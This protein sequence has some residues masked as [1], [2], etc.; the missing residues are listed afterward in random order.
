MMDTVA[1]VCERMA[2]IGEQSPLAP[3][4]EAQARARFYNSANAF[5]IKL[6]AVPSGLLPAPAADALPGFYPCDQ[7][8]D[9][10]SPSVAT[11]PNLLARY[12]QL[13]AGEPLVSHFQA[14]G[15]IWYV[16]SGEGKS[17]IG[18]QTELNWSAG[19]VFYVPGTQL[20]THTAPA[21]AR[22]WV[23]TDEPALAAW[24]L[25]AGSDAQEVVHFT[26]SEIERQLARIRAA[27]ADDDTSGKA[28]IFSTQVLTES[29]N[30]HPVMTLSL[31][32][33]EAGRHQQ[34]HRHNS[35]AITLV[36][37][38]DCSHSL[39]D[40]VPVS[41]REGATMVTPPTAVHSHHNGSA[42]QQ[43]R[44]LIVQDGGFYYR[45]RTMGF[46]SR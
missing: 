46:E 9:M 21:G 33:L 13:G 14:S 37:S 4:S 12:A 31:N 20:C 17:R 22:L 16:L 5:N 8:A 36:V 40:G 1:P 10:Q 34:A 28:L 2:E 43:A 23:V 27:E 18:V 35:A 19:D 30:I 26:A 44:F 25:M 41:W 42:T 6:P 3:A 11:T 29:R 15:A 38:G 39:V 24:G 32:T 45:A 7:S